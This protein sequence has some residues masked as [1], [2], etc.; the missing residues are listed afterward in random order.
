MLLTEQNRVQQ[1]H[2]VMQEPEGSERISLDTLPK[3]RVLGLTHSEMCTSQYDPTQGQ[4]DRSSKKRDEPKVIVSSDAIV[5]PR[6]EV[7]ESQ[8]GS[9]R[10]ST[11]L[12][13]KRTNDTVCLVHVEYCFGAIFQCIIVLLLQNVP[14]CGRFQLGGD[15]SFLVQDISRV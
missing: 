7:I 6:T 12:G 8:H 15:L 4:K 10:D 5:H 9:A 13:T 2:R 11:M 14:S 3:T 1:V